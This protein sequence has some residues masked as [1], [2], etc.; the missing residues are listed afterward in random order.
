MALRKSLLLSLDCSAKTLLDTLY[1]VLCEAVL[2]ARGPEEAQ[3][4]AC[5]LMSSLEASLTFLRMSVS[6]FIT[7]G[8]RR[9]A[10]IVSCTHNSQVTQV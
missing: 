1:S 7:S 3:W 8:S 2:R 9:K 4:L 5:S 6:D 10:S